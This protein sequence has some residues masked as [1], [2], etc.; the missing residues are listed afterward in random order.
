MADQSSNNDIPVVSLRLSALQL[1]KR[2]LLTG[3]D[4][5]AVVYLRDSSHPDD[6]WLEHGRTETLRNAPNPSWVTQFD[7]KFVFE[8]LQEVRVAI[9]DR[10]SADERLTKHDYIGV[11]EF[12]LAQAVTANS[13]PLRLSLTNEIDK[14]RHPGFLEVSC[15]SCTS[16]EPSTVYLDLGVHW[17][18]ATLSHTRQYFQIRR[19]R[20]DA[21]W[22]VVYHSEPSKPFDRHV[23][24]KSAVL[25]MQSLTGG[26]RDCN[27]NFTIFSQRRVSAS[28]TSTDG[29]E[30]ATFEMRYEDLL[31]LLPGS[32]RELVPC[33]VDSPKGLSRLLRRSTLLSPNERVSGVDACGNLIIYSCR[34]VREYEFLDFIL[35]GCELSVSVAIDFS[36][37]NGNP[38]SP[39]SRHYVG[40]TA[41][42]EETT[43][44][45]KVPSTKLA[46]VAIANGVHSEESPVHSGS[47]VHSTDVQ[48]A[49]N[50]EDMQQEPVANGDPDKGDSRA[51]P[52]VVKPKQT[53]N[54][55]AGRDGKQGVVTTQSGSDNITDA[56]ASSASPA[57]RGSAEEP[58]KLGNPAKANGTVLAPTVAIGNDE[59][60]SG[61]KQANGDRISS[62]SEDSG[63]KNLNYK[64]AIAVDQD[65]GEESRGMRV[66]VRKRNRPVRFDSS[67]TA[68]RDS[69]RGNGSQ[70]AVD[71]ENV[72]SQEG[73]AGFPS[74]R[75]SHAAANHS[76]ESEEDGGV[77]DG[78]IR[79]S[80]GSTPAADT[81]QDDLCYATAE[82]YHPFAELERTTPFAH[83][84]AIS[85]NE[86]ELAIRVVISILSNYVS[87]EKYG[88]YGFGALVPRE[89]TGFELS[90][91]F[92]LGGVAV[93]DGVDGIIE[94]YRQTCMC[95]CP[96]LFSMTT[97]LGASSI[98]SSFHTC[99]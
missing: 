70:L 74:G 29:F 80:F 77:Q 30:R 58:G 71:E 69:Q 50:H 8:L 45:R 56:N 90:H 93:C 44:S 66:Q 72:E 19:Q 85:R 16:T 13:S 24:W 94:H 76:R 22:T 62:R 4:P 46:D 34:E 35:G 28:R 98:R 53:P 38:L 65:P 49:D 83:L 39:S 31:Q 43:T 14:K 9:Y 21:S 52:E 75:R 91:C 6:G 5:F 26:D 87:G 7:I 37:S 12:A 89:R 61:E 17:K 10:D 99:C 1:P 86:Y 60:R 54:V 48:R 59:A 55:D 67:A 81:G 88:C 96:L 63:Q 18:N 41:S 95:V 33:S 79:P 2:D 57:G 78:G 82:S 84:E 3:S 92:P 73:K 42:P 68:G 20:P 32:T 40:E 64:K 23:R 97:D 27:L 36:S 25:S 15:E 47:T 11:C 51:R